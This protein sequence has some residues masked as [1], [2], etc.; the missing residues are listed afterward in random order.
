MSISAIIHSFNEIFCKKP[1][2]IHIIN[3]SAEISLFLRKSREAFDVMSTTELNH[4][5]VLTATQLNIPYNMFVSNFNKI[6]KIYINPIIVK[7]SEKYMAIREMCP[8]Y[9]YYTEMLVPRYQ[10]ITLEYLNEIG[11]YKQ[12]LFVGPNSCAVQRAMDILQH[13]LFI[14]STSLRSTP[15]SEVTAKF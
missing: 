11:D 7:T 1:Q 15:C 13:G 5:P 10:S 4:F 14:D 12:Q 3:N 6:Q 2:D 8:S 9:N